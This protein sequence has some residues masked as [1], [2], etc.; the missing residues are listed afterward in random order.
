MSHPDFI[1]DTEGF[2]RR[3]VVRCRQWERRL[4]GFL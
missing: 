1:L 4:D 3:R 2:V